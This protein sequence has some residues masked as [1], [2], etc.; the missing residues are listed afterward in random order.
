[1]VDLQG[2]KRYAKPGALLAMMTVAIAAITGCAATHVAGI[3]LGANA[4]QD[5]E[6]TSN[7]PVIFMGDSI[8]YNWGQDWAGGTF[9]AHSNWVDVGIIG[10]TSGQ[11]DDRFETDVVA[12]HPA[13]VAILAGTNDTYPYWTLCGIG[14]SIDTCHNIAD[15]IQKAKAAGITPILATIPPWGCIDSDNHCALAETADSSPGR[16]VMIDQLN[17]WIKAYG[18]Q[19]GLIVIDY[20]A[21]LVSSDGKT[22]QPDLTIDGVHPMPAGYALMAPM[23]EAAIEADSRK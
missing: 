1:M 14:G 12:K 20:H 3:P 17:G 11:M 22:Y 21:A 9:V 4:A 18:A 10:Q 6:G 23:I 2:L 7:M 8:T 5:Y 19:Q 16:Y 13:M 15:M